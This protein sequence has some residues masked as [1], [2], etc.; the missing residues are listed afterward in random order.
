V[1]AI[2]DGRGVRLLFWADSFWPAIGGME[3]WAAA[4]VR[5]LTAHGY[6]VTVVTTHTGLRV[7]DREEY[8]GAVVHRLPLWETLKANDSAR[9]VRVRSALARLREQV[10]P[11]CVHVNFSGPTILF[12]LLTRHVA[13]APTL[14]T[15]HGEWPDRYTEPGSILVQTLESANW[16]VSVS[17]ATLAWARA[18]CPSLAEHSSVIPPASAGANGTGTP[19]EQRGAP[20]GPPRLL[21]LGRLSHEKGFDLALRAFSRVVAARPDARLTIAGDGTEREPLAELARELGIADKVEFPG[22][23]SPGDVPDLIARSHL[24]LAPS[25]SEGFGLAALEAARMARPVVA[26]AVG[27]LNEIVI[28]GQTG[29][30]VPPQDPDALAG[31]VLALLADP[32]RAGGLGRA[33]R[34]SV[35][36]HGDWETHL[37]AYHDL[38]QSLVRGARDANGGGMRPCA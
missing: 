28:D 15:L 7:P 13:P 27:G 19:P 36:R 4:Y 37:H 23:I 26:A 5:A 11:D 10:R 8:H 32:A 18:F 3:V 24:V 20:S 34:A 29:I 2:P 30:L 22:W 25:R 14:F 21:C 9:L 38:I 31:A 33:A 35:A 17:R 12:Y 6:Q 16:V 1:S